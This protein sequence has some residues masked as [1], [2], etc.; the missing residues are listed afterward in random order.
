MRAARLIE[1]GRGLLALDQPPA[2]VDEV[3][4]WARIGATE[5]NRRAFCELLLTAPGLDRV[6][7]GV[8]LDPVSLRGAR[9]P[10]LI[11]AR[12]VPVG[13]A[14][15][16]SVGAVDFVLRRWVSS[17]SNTLRES[18]G[19]A[20]QLAEWAADCQ[21]A[22]IVPVAE[23]LV[24]VADRDTLAT[25]AQRHTEV[26][27]MVLSAFD[28]AGAERSALVLGAGMPE[29]GCRAGNVATSDD[30][31]RAALGCLREAG[32]SGIAGVVFTA[33]GRGRALVG[34]LAAL[35]WL[36]PD[37]PIGFRLGADTLV[38]VAR[39]WKGRQR[40]TSAAQR[41]LLIQLDTM[42]RTVRAAG[43]FYELNA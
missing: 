20:R 26:F 35:Q 33:Q 15:G 29:P 23:C 16:P 28:R 22:M 3:L 7:G 37:W 10:P 6:V 36:G 1:G 34:H 25:A 5:A 2:R 27:R 11:G 43:R 21:R 4:R 12:P 42:S 13:V 32:A 8:L 39:V 31:A 30:V 9:K 14:H 40:L 38:D 24:R 17:P 19:C 41:E 18:E